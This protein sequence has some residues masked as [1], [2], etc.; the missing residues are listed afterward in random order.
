MAEY[1]VEFKCGC[2]SQGCDSC[3]QNQTNRWKDYVSANSTRQ[4]L[5]K[6]NE[7]YPGAI[8][9]D[10]YLRVWEKKYVWEKK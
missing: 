8:V 10:I 4:A 7:E 9:T 1:L 5:E 3:Q 2:G 6:A